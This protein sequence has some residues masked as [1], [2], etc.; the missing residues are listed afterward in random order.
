M[1][2]IVEGLILILVHDGHGHIYQ[3]TY[4]KTYTCLY[5][6]SFMKRQRHLHMEE[7]IYIHTVHETLI[8]V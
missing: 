5:V 3:P 6:K 2:E 4:Y 1:K 7:K 8:T